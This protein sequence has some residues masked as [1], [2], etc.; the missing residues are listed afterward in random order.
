MP[1]EFKIHRDHNLMVTRFW[2]VVTDEELLD[3]WREGFANPEYEL[4]TDKLTDMSDVTE[5]RV[6]FDALRQLAELVAKKYANSD[7]T[8]RS[9][10]IAP[11]DDCFGSARA[12]EVF[13]SDSPNQLQVF[14]EADQALEWLEFPELTLR[15][16][17]AHSDRSTR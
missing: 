5:F 3:A 8:F 15:E 2:G 16:L 9:A 7:Q 1:L 10:I 12:Y 14:R 4:G 6:G 11:D 17:L 13:R